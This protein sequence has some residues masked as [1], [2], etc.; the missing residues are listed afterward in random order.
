MEPIIAHSG[1]EAIKIATTQ[2]ASGNPFD[3]A[4]L[5]F[6][7][8]EM[9]GHNLC[10]Q[11][12]AT[13]YLANIP[14]VLLSSVDQSVQGSQ[15]RGLGFAGSLVKPVR[16]TAL[17]QIICSVFASESADD[18]QTTGPSADNELATSASDNQT[19]EKT[20]DTGSSVSQANDSENDSMPSAVAAASAPM[21]DVLV[22]ED[23][24]MN[25]MVVSG[26]L[27]KYNVE[28][29]FADNGKLGVEAY[30][31]KTPD[32]ILMDVSMP[33]MNGLDATGEI[34]TYEEAQG[35]PRCPI[36]ALTANAMQ[37]DRELCM[38]AG[39]DDFLTKPVLSKN[40]QNMLAKWLDN[41]NIVNQ[42]AA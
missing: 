41:L 25:Q 28:I 8:P 33:V 38:Q 36:I 3:L 4:I 30:Q 18:V 39:M 40:V 15:L 14:L 37:G 23:N 22:V 31:E 32:L 42:K 35:M 16:N 19:P 34:R 9:D 12:K 27:L 2:V 11:F 1:E 10:Q 20:S 26:F 6:Q 17:H 21:I 24:P 29:R 13:D 7:M 5:D